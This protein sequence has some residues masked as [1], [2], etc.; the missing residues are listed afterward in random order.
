[1]V[2]AVCSVWILPL[3]TLQELPSNPDDRWL[4]LPTKVIAQHPME[5]VVR[6]A[7]FLLLYILRLYD[8][9]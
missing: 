2:Y 4:V 5:H 3:A 9:S 7:T 6:E 1:M 8:L